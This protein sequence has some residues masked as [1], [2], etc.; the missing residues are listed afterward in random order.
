MK[1]S[2]IDIKVG[3]IL[4]HKNAMYRVSDIEHVKPGKGGAFMQVEMKGIQNGTKLNERFRS[5]E[6]V[7][8]VNFESKK[9]QYMYTDGDNLEIMDPQTYEQISARKTLLTGPEE[10][11]S[12]GLTL[13]V[14]FADENAIAINLP[15][16]VVATVLETQ[17]YIKGQTA[18]SSFKPAVLDNGVTVQVPDYLGIGEK[19]V[20]S[21][22]KLEYLEKYKGDK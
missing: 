18:K 20:V 11:L 7:E 22:A 8:K 13:T 3:N 14:D 17:P 6:E 16:S 2:A 19:I 10:F 5:S 1:I 15:E 12:D 21:T 9:M 4:F